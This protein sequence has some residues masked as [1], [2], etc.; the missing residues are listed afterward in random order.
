MYEINN[1]S[2]PFNIMVGA[3]QRERGVHDE[4]RRRAARRAARGAARGAG[5]RGGR[6]ALRAHHVNHTCW[7][8]VYTVI[9]N[10]YSFDL[11]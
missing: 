9:F 10:S 4:V 8:Q 7:G 3:V 5:R 1:N 2:V 11:G 6:A